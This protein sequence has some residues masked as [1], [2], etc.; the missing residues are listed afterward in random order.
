MSTSAG[1]GQAARSTVTA[2]SAAEPDGPGAHF[3][4]LLELETDCA[5]VASD[6]A[7]GTADFVLLDVRSAD[8]YDAGH[9]AGARNLP[10]R[11]ISPTTLADFPAG[12][13]RRL[14]RR[15]CATAPTAAP[16]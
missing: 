3:A 13:V 1:T 10:H 14:L 7:A 4:R 12:D 11:Q 9:V 16:P 5:D 6:L 15:A 8:A 2:V